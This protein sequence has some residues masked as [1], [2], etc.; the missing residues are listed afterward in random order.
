MLDTV[1]DGHLVTAVCGEGTVGNGVSAG[2]RILAPE[3]VERGGNLLDAA[4]LLLNS[5]SSML[6]AGCFLTN[7][8]LKLDLDDTIF[9]VDRAV[10]FEVGEAERLLAKTT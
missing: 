9:I 8:L 7:R 10:P 1:R 2:E 5:N 6:L 3:L 4:G